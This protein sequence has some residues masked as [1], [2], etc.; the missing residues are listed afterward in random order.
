[1]CVEGLHQMA[2]I[3]FRPLQ[4]TH[5]LSK[6][7][8]FYH[9][10]LLFLAKDHLALLTSSLW[11]ASRSRSEDSMDRT[12]RTWSDLLGPILVLPFLAAQTWANF[13]TSLCLG[14]QH[15][16]KKKWHQFLPWE[17]NSN[18][19]F[20]AGSAGKES[21]CKA[22]DP[23]SIPGWGRSPGEGNGNPLHSSCWRIPWTKK[24]GRLQSMGLQRVRHDFPWPRFPPS[25]TAPSTSCWKTPPVLT[26]RSLVNC[27]WF[28]WV[29]Y[30][31]PYF[32]NKWTKAASC[33]WSHIWNSAFCF[34]AYSIKFHSKC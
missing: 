32:T 19:G 34:I 12:R 22:G 20:P 7:A 10:F 31:C 14:F 1:M 8:L 30:Y 6:N 25:I 33:C 13:E 17:H 15:H 23:S 27:Q 4:C 24:P 5:P 28:H 11:R 2:N 16:T 9:H 21:V 29:C 26:S 3:R 18:L